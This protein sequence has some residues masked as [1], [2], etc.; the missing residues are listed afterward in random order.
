MTYFDSLEYDCWDLVEKYCEH[1]GI[2]MIKEDG[3]AVVSFDIVKDIQER[4]LDA[5]QDAGVEL[6]FER[7]QSEDSGMIMGGM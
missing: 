6:N 5:V 2:Q 4:I 7:Q 1:L 3:E